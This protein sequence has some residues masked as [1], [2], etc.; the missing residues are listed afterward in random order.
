[1]QVIRN[2]V[3]ARPRLYDRARAIKRKLTGRTAPSFTVLSEFSRAR[4]GK[5]NFIQI[6]ANDGLR[7]DPVRPLV[8]RDDWQG[9]LVEPLPT[10]F[11]LLQRNYAYLGR[12]GLVFLNAAVAAGEGDSLEFW[13]FDDDFLDR[14]PLELRLDYLRKASFVR[15]HVAGFLPAEV[16]PAEVL[17]SVPVPCLALE[18][19]LK[20]HLPRH[21]LHLVA[22]DA[23]GY[24]AELIPAIDFQAVPC[25][26]V[27]YESE[28]LGQADGGRIRDHLTS[29]GFT[30]QPLGLDSLA[31][32]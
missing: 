22:I 25:E 18:D 11:P 2:F 24:E 15:D 28:H 4:G 19:V 29:H 21:P 7:N 3:R 23:E 10:V 9:V 26:A 1:V 20:T 27:F 31:L 5:V 12:E 30:I 14:Q 17:T 16:D 13:S 6:G 32:R 8:I